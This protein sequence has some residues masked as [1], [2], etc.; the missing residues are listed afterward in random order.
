MLRTNAA[1]L[2][3]T[4]ILAGC[5]ESDTIIKQ[6]PEAQIDQEL[7][8]VLDD[9]GVRAVPA[10]PP[11]SAQLVEL[12]RALFFDKELSGNR[13]IS[14]ATCHHPAA[15]TG[16]ALP[17]SIGEGGHGLAENRS[18][19]GGHLIP[20]NA[21]HVFNAGVAGVRSMF[22][23][24]RVRFDPIA[25]ELQTPESGL[26]GPAPA[27]PE[28][29]A[30]LRSALAAQAMFP[31]TSHDEMRGQAGSNEIADAADNPDVWSK[32]MTRLGNIPEY[33]ALFLA[34]YPGAAQF[35]ELNFG[36][37]ARAIAAFERDAWTA[38]DT[39]FDR[40]LGGDDS[41]LSNPEKRGALLYFG[42]AQCG[43]CHG[44]P[45]LT[46][47]SHHA[48]AVPQVGPGKNAVQEDLGLA[49]QT[50]DPKDN[51]KFRT[52]PLRNVALTGPWMH[53]GCF[54]SLDAAVRHHLDCVSSIL[55]YDAN[56]L[57]MLFRDTV[58]ADHVQDRID[59]LPPEFRVPMALSEP[60]IADLMAFLHAL[61]DPSSLNLSDDVPDRVPSGLP[62][63]E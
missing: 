52:P 62:V 38:L 25:G 28:L 23:D 50:G 22:W 9:A 45:L 63:G 34:A 58:D 15:G 31:V 54:T 51:Y 56:Q 3:L 5:G 1:L 16:D 20:R 46:D 21:P 7:R 39:P 40:Y 53:D 36:H 55:A 29:A 61:T 10:P 27:L 19:D 11:E 43:A 35:D 37:A 24:S 49:L 30:P 57:P 60:E 14:C 26:N 42:K 59:A 17:V 47:F 33:R 41:A 4:L 32:L 12:G 18:L 13:N 6:L 48:L 44:G 8:E 2:G